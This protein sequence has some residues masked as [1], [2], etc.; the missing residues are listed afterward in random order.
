MAK[1]KAA[2]K[3]PMCGRPTEADT[4]PFCSKRC[5]EADLARWLGGDYK[6][7]T[8]E[9]PGDENKPSDDD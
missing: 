4:A 5:A 2:K 6:I 3:C 7:P 8:N 9:K 1:R